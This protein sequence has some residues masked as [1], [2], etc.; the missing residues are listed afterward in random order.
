MILAHDAAY[1]AENDWFAQNSFGTERVLRRVDNMA[2]SMFAIIGEESAFSGVLFELTLCCDRSY[3]MEDEDGEVTFTMNDASRG[4]YLMSTGIT[5]FNADS[6]GI[7]MP[8]ITRSPAMVRLMR[9][10]QR[11]WHWLQW[12]SMTLTG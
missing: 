5:D 3:M 4:R 7:P 10:R 11:T 8:L 12:R 1:N 9:P 6:W 2:K